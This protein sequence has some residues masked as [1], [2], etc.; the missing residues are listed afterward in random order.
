MLLLFNVNGQVTKT[1]TTPEGEKVI[2]KPDGT[3]EF[4]KKEDPATSRLDNPEERVFSIEEYKSDPV[5]YLGKPF[6]V[7]CEASSSDYYNF[8][9]I[10][11]Q[12]THL[13]ISL[14][15]ETSKRGFYFINA[16]MERGELADKLRATLLRSKEPVVGYFLL[17]LEKQVYEGSSRIANFVELKEYELLDELGPQ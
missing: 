1:A 15:C 5:R 10:R 17:L 14:R 13:S 9:F 6:I 7:K 16:Y 12:E 8:Y 11:S 4:A 2:L 3:W